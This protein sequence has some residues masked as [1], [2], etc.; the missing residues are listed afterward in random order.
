MW[1]KH[2]LC[3]LLAAALL[4][5]LTVPALGKRYPEKEH[6]PVDYAGMLPVTGFDETALTEALEEL[7]R[8]CQKNTS[9]KGQ[10]R[11]RVRELYDRILSEMNAFITKQALSGVQYDAGGGAPE[12]AALYLELSGQWSRLFD[13]CYQAFALL[14][15]SPYREVLD[16][17]AGEGTARSLLGYEGATEDQSA[18]WGR[19][20]RLVQE[21]DQIISKGV[22]VETEGRTWTWEDLEAVRPEGEAYWE[23]A[24]AL[25]DAR[26]RAAGELYREL[27]ALRTEIAR[28]AGYDSYADYAYWAQYN[29][30]YT[31]EDAAPLRE[32]A[33]EYIL[34][35]QLQ[36]SERLTDQDIRALDIRSRRSGEELLDSVGPFIRDFDREMGEAFD[37]MRAHHLYDIEFSPEKLP[38]SY[39]LALPAYGSAF[40][41]LSP[42][43]NYQDYSDLVHEFGHFNETFYC[44]QHELWADFNIDVGEIDSQAL[45]LIFTGYAGELF[46]E[47][48]GQVYQDL[49]LYNILDSVLEGC[50]YDEFQAAVYENPELSLEELNRLF[51]ELSEEYGYA[52]EDGVEEDASWVEVSHN[53]QNPLYF[54]SY[55][56][57]ALAAL[58]LW[59]LYLDSPRQGREVYLDLSALS[60]SR[61]YREAVEAVGLGDVFEP[62]TVPAL[63]EML[64]A[65]LNGEPVS[66]GGRG[67]PTALAV[68]KVLAVVY[69]LFCLVWIVR[70]SRFLSRNKAW[71]QVSRSSKPRQTD[72]SE[73]PWALPDKKPPWEL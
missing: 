67:H 33:K 29:R 47:R 62:E 30:D 52:Y 35:L 24:S 68:M 13:R 32:A 45:E 61:P 36:L 56:T 57:S 15:A 37:F 28:E 18:L 63:A 69:I 21:Y 11:D 31:L 71:G 38:T 22:P 17:S 41:F 58:D 54:I 59:F 3:L 2:L 73:D 25:E 46:G 53:F 10:A 60:L 72:G 49:I 39:T 12:D 5:G 7:E 40:I 55:A 9:S 14:A 51:K 48:Y 64:E 19:E 42:Y 23:I 66:R 70:C 8:I 43:G 50:L 34:P 26:S 16:D 44:A 1:K 27:V 4:A 20:D 65:H 6:L